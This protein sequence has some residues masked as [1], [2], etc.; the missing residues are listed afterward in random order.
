MPRFAANLSTLFTELPFRSRFTAARMAGF[1][2]VELTFPYDHPAEALA[3]ELGMQNM[4]LVMFSAP[5]GDWEAGDR[6]LAAL[7]GRE[8]QFEA[9]IEAALAYAEMTGCPIVNVM[10]GILPP[11]VDPDHA[12]ATL[13]ANLRQ[14]AEAAAAKN[15]M[16]VIEPV[17]TAEM[18]GYYLNEFPLAVRAL[19]NLAHPNVGLLFDVYSRQILH[20][21]VAASIQECVPL[22]RH[23]QIANAPFRVDPEHGELN[24]DYLFRL[25]DESGYDGWVGCEYNPLNGTKASLEWFKP[26]R[27]KVML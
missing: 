12:Y 16:L 14:A 11:M 8:A 24:F 25:I 23:Y 19:E 9:S 4:Q 21:D 18:P 10:A 2:A 7:P 1:D 6:G 27:T 22:T 3:A 26:Y 5:A 15:V 20:G 13:L 17:S